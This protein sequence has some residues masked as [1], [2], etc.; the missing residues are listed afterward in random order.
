MNL[1]ISTENILEMRTIK[2]QY[3]S[4]LWRSLKANLQDAILKETSLE[5]LKKALQMDTQDLLPFEEKKFLFERIL[6]FERNKDNLQNFAWW[7]ELNGAPDWDDLAE[8][9]LSEAESID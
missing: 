6:S 8:S 9:L 1:I 5:I 3:S 2:S 4:E 7:L